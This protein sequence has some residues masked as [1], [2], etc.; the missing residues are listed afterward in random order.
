MTR[1]TRDSGTVEQ[2]RSTQSEP[3]RRHRYFKAAVIVSVAVIMGALF[4]VTYSIALGRPVPRHIPAALVSPDRPDPAIISALQQA[5]NGAL[6]FRAYASFDAARAAIDK[7][8]VY[9]ALIL[10]PGR[11]ATVLIAS[12]AGFSVARVLEQAVQR[13]E[14]QLGRPLDIQDVRPLPRSDPQGLVPFYVTIA[15]TFVGFVTIFQ[16]RANVGDLSMR[17]WLFA[18]G[19]LAVLIGIA[20]TVVSGPVLGALRGP[21]DQL[22]GAFAMQSAVAALF[23]STMLVI[24]AQWAIVPTWLLFIVLGNTSSGGAVAPPLLPPLLAWLNRFAPSGATVTLVHDAAY[25]P[26]AAH[27]QPLVVDACWLVGTLAA[28]IVAVRVTHRLPT[29]KSVPAHTMI[30]GP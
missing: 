4:A 3:L 23:A 5:T 13:A 6:D 20:L 29:G 26:H 22:W 18:V 15:A 25:F 14:S 27:L 8:Q 2:A 28:L 11:A 30:N 21:T 16:L 12:A 1:G 17:E 7:R 9:A 19:A 24:I 10:A